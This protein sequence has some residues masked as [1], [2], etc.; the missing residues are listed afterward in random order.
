MIDGD[1]NDFLTLS[2]TTGNAGTATISVTVVKIEGEERMDTIVITTVGGTGVLKDTIIVTQEAVPTIVVN[3]PSMIDI[4]Y[5]AVID[6]TITFDVGGSATAWT[7][8]SDQSFVTLDMT[9]GAS[10]TGI[11][12]MATVT[13]NMDVLLRTATITITTEGQLGAA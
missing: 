5:N 11:E 8:S 1:A 9:S 13:E 2:D 12:V 3:T 7:A 6:T 10:G 4:D